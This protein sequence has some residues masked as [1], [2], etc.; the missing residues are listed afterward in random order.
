MDKQ[1]SLPSPNEFPLKTEIQIR[2]T[3]VDMYKHINNTRYLDYYDLGKARYFQE[4][5]KEDLAWRIE[6][7]LTVIANVN[8]SFIKSIVFGNKISVLTRCEKIGTKSFVIHQM[9]V[10]EKP[11]DIYSECRTVMVC[12]N[13]DTH[14]SM[15]VPDSWRRCFEKFEGRKL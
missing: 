1:Q 5:T 13:P 6:N 4:A 10:G 8:C 14:E 9:I 3:D 11:E 2:T 15:L 7:M 12:V